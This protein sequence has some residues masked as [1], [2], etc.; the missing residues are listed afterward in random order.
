MDRATQPR[1]KATR[2]DYRGAITGVIL[3]THRQDV[4]KVLPQIYIGNGH[5][6]PAGELAA[7]VSALPSGPCISGGKQHPG[8]RWHPRCASCSFCVMLWRHF[9]PCLRC[10]LNT[11]SSGCACAGSQAEAVASARACAIDLASAAAGH[12]CSDELQAM[13][14]TSVPTVAFA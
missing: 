8:I 9:Q 3:C 14:A 7:A 10:C 1:V 6:F 12:A 2:K 13:A 4:Q 11:Y 5:V